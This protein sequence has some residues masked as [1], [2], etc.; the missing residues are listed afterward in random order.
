M[1]PRG[2]AAAGSLIAGGRPPCA[3]GARF[4][5]FLTALI[6][7]SGFG[8]KTVVARATISVFFRPKESKGMRLRR[9]RPVPCRAGGGYF[10][11][12]P[13]PPPCRERCQNWPSGPSGGGYSAG[14]PAPP[15]RRE[16]CQNWLAGFSG[17]LTPR[18]T[19]H[20][21]APRALIFSLL[22][23]AGLAL[24]VSYRVGSAAIFLTTYRII[25]V[26]S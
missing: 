3:P 13:A 19:P 21:P 7:Y 11:G 9:G 26:L 10:A 23:L 12:D 20:P 1:F 2:G 14:D 6:Q 16:R 8:R 25:V 5:A 24:Q 17:P 15:P 4:C 22:A 18:D